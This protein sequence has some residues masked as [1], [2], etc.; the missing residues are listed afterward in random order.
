MP[1]G[2]PRGDVLLWCVATTELA[3]HRIDEA[4]FDQIVAS[5]ALGEVRVEL[6]D[7]LLVD[8]SPPSPEHD[9]IIERLTMHLARAE[10]RGPRVQLSIA[11]S[12]FSVLLPD[13]SLV[14]GPISFTSRP[15]TARLVI[16]VAVTSHWLDS[17]RKAELYAE[18]GVEEYWIVDVPGRCVEVRR[19]GELR[20][21]RRGETVPSP[22]P[23]VPELSVDA[24]FDGLP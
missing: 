18:A 22:A 23:G 11:V 19:G 9:G 16:E 17:G 15:R 3:L 14:D 21:Y 20:T 2:R 1:G 5:G 6:I 24:L 10:G 13:L 12:D 7:G 8:M 4:R